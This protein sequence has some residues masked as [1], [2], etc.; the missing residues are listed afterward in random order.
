MRTDRIVIFVL[1]SAVCAIAQKAV[2][3]GTV[4]DEN[5]AVIAGTRIEFI[6]DKGR[7][8]TGP[9][10]ADGEYRIELESGLYKVIASRP[11]FTDAVLTNYWVPRSSLKLDIALRCI[12]C[13][14]LD[15]LIDRPQPVEATPAVIAK[16]IQTRPL[17]KSPT[18]KAPKAKTTKKKKKIIDE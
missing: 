12:D 11:P 1:C 16:E 6:S 4:V 17:E 5:G 13:Q 9:T 15:D 18:A 8:Y 3:T 2:V 14:W 7:N 10:N